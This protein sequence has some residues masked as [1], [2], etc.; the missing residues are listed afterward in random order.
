MLPASERLTG[1]ASGRLASPA[2]ATVKARR[3]NGLNMSACPVSLPGFHRE[4]PDLHLGRFCPT[5]ASTPLPDGTV[6]RG[7]A[8]RILSMT[9]TQI[10][11]YLNAGRLRQATGRMDGRSW[12]HEV[13]AG[14]RSSRPT[15][16]GELERE[17]RRAEAPP[18]PTPAL[19]PDREATSEELS[20]SPSGPRE[21]GPF[22]DTEGAAQMS[23]SRRGTS[24]GL[25]VRGA[26]RGCPQGDQV[27]T[28]REGTGRHRSSHRGHETSGRS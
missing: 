7:E 9:K 10:S 19:P 25:Q 20:W 12:R 16:G 11:R 17:R 18:H 14:R 15:Q 23:A 8:A 13:G 24:A 22:V 3:H 5:P 26:C 4:K 27:V 1:R 21:S 2:Y 6:I 28:R